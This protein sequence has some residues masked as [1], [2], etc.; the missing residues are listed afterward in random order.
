MNSLRIAAMKFRYNHRIL[1]EHNDATVPVTING[2]DSGSPRRGLHEARMAKRDWRLG[3]A[4]PALICALAC[5]AAGACKAP[6]QAS[7]PGPAAIS[8]PLAVAEPAPPPRAKL[9]PDEWTSDAP[10][11]Q[12]RLSH[13]PLVAPQPPA[14]PPLPSEKAAGAAPAPASPPAA[15]APATLEL[16]VKDEPKTCKAPEP[17]PGPVQAAPP[18]KL[19]YQPKLGRPALDIA[20]GAPPPE[21]ERR[22]RLAALLAQ[23]LEK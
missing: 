8:R 15:T 5:C 12:A 11:F 9:A 19:S 1:G 2:Q 14:A 10:A 4:P 20:P 13:T 3:S 6:P 22:V 21:Q 23:A 18:L 16:A 17:E 7:V